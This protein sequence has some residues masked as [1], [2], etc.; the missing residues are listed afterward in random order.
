MRPPARSPPGTRRPG[1]G[2]SASGELGQLAVTFDHMA[3]DL[4]RAEQTRRQLAA[5]VA[6]ELRTPLAVAI[7]SHS[8]E[9]SALGTGPQCATGATD[10]RRS[11]SDLSRRRASGP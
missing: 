9:W 11:V 2:V 7:T 6:H 3:T 4:T 10:H 8:R 5:D 1:L